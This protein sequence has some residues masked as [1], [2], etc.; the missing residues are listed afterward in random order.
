[1]NLIAQD[2]FR[3]DN[4]LLS[5]LS[6]GKFSDQD[7]FNIVK[8]SRD[9]KRIAWKVNKKYNRILQSIFL[10]WLKGEQGINTR[11][12][13]A[14]RLNKKHLYKLMKDNDIVVRKK[15]AKR[16]PKKYLRKMI[17]DDSLI[18]LMYI[19]NR[20]PKN[21]TIKLLNVCHIANLIYIVH[22]LQVKNNKYVISIFRR[23]IS[24]YNFIINDKKCTHLNI[25]KRDYFTKLE[26]WY[27]T[28]PYLKNIVSKN[29]LRKVGLL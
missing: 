5:N 25:Y 21:H 14:E 18:V 26:S 19:F 17:Y 15:V 13:L 3:T 16:I 8:N 23:A 7:A 24:D 20:L 27:L 4:T 10:E 6:L 29:Q 22:P 9:P 11:V 28:Y 2:L 12:L 1:M